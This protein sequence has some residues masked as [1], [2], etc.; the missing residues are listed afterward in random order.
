[1]SAPLIF[2]NSKGIGESSVI[3]KTAVCFFVHY[4]AFPKESGTKA[5]E[6]ENGRNFPAT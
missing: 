2:A 4:R 3:P 1:M 6:K 5:K